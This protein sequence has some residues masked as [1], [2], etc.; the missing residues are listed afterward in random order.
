M[1]RP[2]LRATLAAALLATIL[3]GC[4]DN[5]SEEQ[6]LTDANKKIEALS[7]RSAI[8]ELRN[9][10]RANPES[11]PARLALARVLLEVNDLD[12]AEKE[13]SRARDLGASSDDTLGLQARIL[14][15]RGD[16]ATLLAEMDP[17]AAQSPVLASE[18]SALRGRAMLALGSKDEARTVFEAVLADGK[19]TEAQR[20]SLLGLASMA[21]ANADYARAEQLARQSLEIAPD[22]AESFL[23][24]GQLLI[25]QTRFDDANEFLSDENSAGVR[26]ARMD[27]FRLFGER[28][29]ALLGS[30]DLDAADEAVQAMTRIATN[31]PMSGFLRG[32]VAYR[33]GD[34]DGALETIQAVVAK[35]PQFVPAQ[36]LLGAI[37][38]KRGDLEQAE[39]YLSQAIAA[40]PSNTGARQLLA[41]TRM[42]MQRPE[43]AARTLREG[44]RNDGNNPALLAMLGRATVR[45]GQDTEGIEILRRSLEADPNNPQTI[46][47]LAAA[48][49][50]QEKRAE[51]VELIETLPA[52]ALDE[53]RRQV[54]TL[55]ASFDPDNP[56]E[57][58][59]MLE[60]LLAD[61]PEDVALLNLAG[62][63]Y[64]TTEDYAR[65]RQAF[66]QV[67]AAQ[68][69]NRSALTGMLRLDEREGDYSRSRELFDAAVNANPNDL[70]SVLVLARIAEA[71]GNHDRA[72]ELVTRAH[73]I[74]E[75][76]LLPN[77]SLAGEGLRQ[78][79]L[80]AAERHARLAIT[81][82]ER[83]PQAQE[84][85]GLIYLRKR[86]FDEALGYLKRAVTL[87]PDNYFYHY[88]LG[89]A[90]LGAGQLAQARDSFRESFR[91]NRNHLASLRSLAVLEVRAGESQRAD[92]LL[93]IAEE[94]LGSGP[95]LDELVGDVRSAQR[96]HSEAQSAYRR[97]YDTRS[98]WPLARKLFLTGQQTGT[99]DATRP[100]RE[101][102][103]EHPGHVPARV[104]LAQTFHR[105]NEPLKAI[106][107]YEMLIIDQ[108]DSAYALN[109]LA[110]LYYTQE[111]GENRQR[112]LEMAD[113][114]HRLA[115]L[116][117]DITDTLGWIQF[118]SG[119]VDAGLETLREAMA[120]TTPRRSPD[121]AYHLAAVLHETGAS[122]EARETLIQALAS[123][124]PFENRDDA[125]RLLDSL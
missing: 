8:I 59:S 33:R 55:V 64:L 71:G 40:E 84:A 68:P 100:L 22:S 44:L 25:V 122:G 24:I 54:L 34:Y 47:A 4:G 11:L 124:R 52:G 73:A 106:E 37:S 89:G 97:A 67:L 43:D 65:A 112:A 110:W 113:K 45:L 78:D 27:K 123:P 79:D 92:Q 93:R 26:L 60:Q 125:Q 87:D 75:R 39:V 49:I 83:A 53:R 19:S 17:D 13:V 94:A 88:Q 1:T 7:Y 66:E 20:V 69:D 120:A 62:S 117:Y 107:Q 95:I 46:I 86:Q 85:M 2:T 36:Q 102:L 10:L 42:Q 14:S 23:Q 118:N 50:A 6:R 12:A 121:I 61:A 16:H 9:V 111:G 51:A 5:R 109:N 80:E 81:H 104:L 21:M 35:F 98:S 63:F 96:K 101:W 103:K 116:N 76:A 70:F 72:I 38:L 91:L 58:Q 114:A 41:E 77:L 119:Q 108:P 82:H 99:P 15:A 29:Q 74:D 115:P 18:L 3:T 48:Y 31:H 56:G 90:H 30:G 105:A 57:A 32:Q 28:A